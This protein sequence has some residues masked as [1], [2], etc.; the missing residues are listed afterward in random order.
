MEISFSPVRNWKSQGAKQSTIA[1]QKDDLK[2]TGLLRRMGGGQGKGE[3]EKGGREK[4]K[5]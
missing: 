4:T 2:R 3:E 5:P 1:M